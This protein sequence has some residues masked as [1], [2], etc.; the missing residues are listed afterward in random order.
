MIPN[1]PSSEYLYSEFLN[2]QIFLFR[3]FCYPFFFL[4]EFSLSEFLTVRIL[5]TH[6]GYEIK[7]AKNILWKQ[8]LFQKR[9]KNI[10]S[11]WVVHENNIPKEVSAEKS[12]KEFNKI[13][14]IQKSVKKSTSW[15]I[16]GKEKIPI[17]ILSLF[18][19]HLLYYFQFCSLKNFFLHKCTSLPTDFTGQTVAESN[20][21]AWK[22]NSEKVRIYMCIG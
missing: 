11:D 10:A 7:T 15:K 8:V 9:D 2:I 1:F 20:T 12:Q 18:R 6:S 19:S 14:H 4:S 17:T 3:I 5:N 21:R 22:K 16:P 13:I